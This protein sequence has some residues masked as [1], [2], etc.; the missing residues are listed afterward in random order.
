MR[1]QCRG[2]SEALAGPRICHRTGVIEPKVC[3]PIFTA[4]FL[5]ENVLYLMDDCGNR[6]G[7]SC[8]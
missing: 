7:A 6:L 8:G 5:D 1:T 4:V 2:Q 3:S